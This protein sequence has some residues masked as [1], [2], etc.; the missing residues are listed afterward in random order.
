MNLN[1]QLMS[2]EQNGQTG[3]GGP[4]GQGGQGGPVGQGG[5]GGPV[6]QGGQGGSRGH[7]N[8]V[9]QKQ[10]TMILFFHP[11]SPA[12]KKIIP[13]LP[14]DKHI[15][16]VNVAQLA[17]IPPS[18]VSIP[19]LVINN[20]KILKGKEL[21]N[22]LNSS[23]DMEYIDLPFKSSG[24]TY[25]S[26]SDSDTVESTHSFTGINNMEYNGVPSWSETDNEKSIDIDQY[27]KH[28]DEVMTNIQQKS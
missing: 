25:S 16:K 15:E 22:F 14:K 6:G 20:S 12:C 11:D 4:V 17:T 26:L 13:L 9:N 21:F 27:Q 19:S 28:R 2:R 10:D 23:D 5:Q 24:I 7:E 1:N 8:N 18:I 3:Q